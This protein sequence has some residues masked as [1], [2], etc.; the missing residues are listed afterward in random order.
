MCIDIELSYKMNLLPVYYFFYRKNFYLQK[1]STKKISIYNY[2]QYLQP[3]I[4][5]KTQKKQT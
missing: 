1:N 3:D 2:V 5:K 4:L